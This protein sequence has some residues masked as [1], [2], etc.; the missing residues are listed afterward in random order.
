MLRIGGPEV[1]IDYQMDTTTMDDVLASADVI[2][3]HLPFL[4]APVLSTG[5]FEKMKDGVMIINCAR[6]GG[7][8]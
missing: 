3:L 7:D 2:S 6:G 1:S 4:G 5:E 8:H